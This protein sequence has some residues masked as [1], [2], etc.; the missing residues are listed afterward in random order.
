MISALLKKY[1]NQIGDSIWSLFGL[2]L[3]NAMAQIAVYPLLARQFGEVRYGEIQYLM[4]YV[5]II[6]VSVGCACNLARMTS[7]AEERM[8]NGGDYNLFLLGVCLL[9]VPFVLLVCRFGGVAMTTAEQLT[10]YLLFVAMAFRYYADVAFKLTLNYRRYFL[11]YLCICL[12]YGVGA[13]LA[14]KTGIW[15]LAILTGEAAGI[16]FAYVRGSALRA[17]ALKPSPAFRRTVRAILTLFVAE[18]IANLIFN[19]DRLLLKFLIGATAVTVYYLATLVGKTMSLVTGPL[20]GVLIGYLSRYEGNLSRRA[21]RWIFIG[22]LI[23]IGVFTG[24]CVVGGYLMLLL[25]YPD[26]LHMVKEFLFV[27]SLAQVIYFTTGMVTVILIRFA[28][29]TY[30]IY[31]NAAF[32]ISFFGVG[33][34]ATVLFGIWGFAVAMVIASATRFAVA[35]ALGFRWVRKSEAEMAHADTLL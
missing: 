17:R 6:T 28:K 8:Q 31:I 24:V 14:W 19:V 32:G 9:G 3:M 23:A 26:Q 16:V 27:G 21:M 10:Y 25:L 4:A 12:G 22:A 2:V 13:F 1:R 30:Q 20:N 34:P 15:P 5:N 11:Y 18:G 7:P 33:I 35:M 29:K